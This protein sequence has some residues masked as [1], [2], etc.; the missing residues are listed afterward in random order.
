[1]LS[2][3]ILKSIRLKPFQFLSIV[4]LIAMASFMYVTLQGAIDSVRYFLTDYTTQTNQEDFFVV[5]SPPTQTDLKELA[6]SKDESASVFSHQSSLKK[7]NQ[8]SYT[9]IDY[10]EHQI[11]LLSERF[12]VTF[13]GRFYRDIVS[14]MNDETVRY[15]VINQTDS[16]NMTYLLAGRMPMADDEIAVFETFAKGNNLGIGDNLIINDQSFEITAFIA[17]PDY[18]YP[19]FNYDSPLYE[20]TRE[21]VAIVTET[22]YEKFDEKQWVLYS[23]SFNQEVDDLERAVSK[24][25]NTD[26]VSYAM[27]KDQNV[28]I[29]A[30]DIHLNSN[31]LL[32]MTF[33]AL[34]LVMS[35]FVILIVMKKRINSERVQIGVLKAMGYHR[36]QIALSYMSY[37]LLSTVLGSLIGFFLG[38]G[39]SIYL[40]N[41]YVTSY[42]VPFVRFYFKGDLIIGG[43]IF[44]LIVVSL[45]SLVILIILLRDE[46]LTLMRE[47]S[48][49]KL[50]KSS[51]LMKLALIPFKFETRFKYSLAFRNIGKLLSL[52][53]VVMVASIFLVFSSIIFHSVEN[54]VD[55]AFKGAQYSYQIKYNKLV[56]ESLTETESPFLQYTAHPLLEGSTTPF[57]LYGIIPGNSVNPLYNHLGEEITSATTEGLV[58][59]EFIAR[60]YSLQIGDTLSFEVKGHVLT[61]PVVEIVDHYNGPMMYTSLSQLANDLELKPNVYNGKW[62]CERPLSDKNISYVF[63]IDDLT[64]NIE[65]GM[66]MIRISLLVMV[67]VAMILGSLMMVLITTFIIE[68]N[69]KQIS[70]LKVMGYRKKEISKMVLTIYFPFVMVAYFISIPIT[71]LG[72]DYLMTLI[73]SELPIAIPTDFTFIQFLIGG[74]FVVT[75]YFISLRLSQVQLDNVSLHEVL[76]S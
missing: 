47:N 24:I 3:N 41:T 21:T 19:V 40:A 61:Y 55:K 58:I 68:E 46:P 27:S 2:K 9:L 28:R 64:R 57:Y 32:S 14:E 7:T 60:A 49:L 30:I 10:Y 67:G 33:T 76:K 53:S 73:A 39:T 45:A 16:V 18:I 56:D 37:P 35:I 36:Y 25:S 51:K 71:R 74:L 62:S 75:T 42:V 6:A 8:E 72:I 11:A 20:P 31:Q 59:N 38:V 69:Q 5:L 26:G 12:D 17:V 29:N 44:P 48:N 65:V 63:S 22:A 66:E 70:I 15:R 23:G 13:E 52:F 4:V 50:S 34:L 54:I 43:V 1:M